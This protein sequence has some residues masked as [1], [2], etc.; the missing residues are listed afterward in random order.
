MTHRHRAIRT[1]TRCF[2]GPVRWPENRA[3]HGNVEERS[4]CRCGAERRANVNGRHV[5]RGA[6]TEAPEVRQ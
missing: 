4:Y 5:E 3:A 1:V 6:W 2:S